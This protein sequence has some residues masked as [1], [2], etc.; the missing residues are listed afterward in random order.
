MAVVLE[1]LTSGGFTEKF[2]IA[3][4]IGAENA[5]FAIFGELFK[6]LPAKSSFASSRSCADDVKP[7]RKNLMLVDIVKA[8]FAIGEFFI[9]ACL[10]T[11]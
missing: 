9:R 10:Q 7:R 3:H 1:K 11:I 8:S 5:G 2:K 4:F 6:K